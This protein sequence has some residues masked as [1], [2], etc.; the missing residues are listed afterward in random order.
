GVGGALAVLTWKG[1]AL[2][3]EAVTISFVA[4]PRLAAIGLAI[5]A[6]TGIAAGILPA[7]QAARIEIVRALRNA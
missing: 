3:A 2:G 4:S 5:A 1:F 6:L 7:W